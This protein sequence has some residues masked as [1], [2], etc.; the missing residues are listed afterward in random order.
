MTALCSLLA[1]SHSTCCSS[2][3]FH[4]L[5]LGAH[6]RF[7]WQLSQVD[8]FSG[9]CLLMMK[10]A[11]EHRADNFCHHNS[12]NLL[13][14]Y[15]C[16]SELCVSPEGTIEANN[17]NWRAFYRAPT[18]INWSPVALDCERAHLINEGEKE[19]EEAASL[20]WLFGVFF[21][22]RAQSSTCVLA[23]L[24]VRVQSLFSVCVVWVKANTKFAVG[25][26]KL[27]E[28]SEFVVLWAS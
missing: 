13:A 5:P 12:D 18:T 17:C 11:N 4:C 24:C 3:F 23:A 8:A 19:E 20:I 10:S 22:A 2:L 15:S 9:C 16:C 7:V 25:R 26:V 14:H 27:V 6:F 21:C 1:C 28:Q